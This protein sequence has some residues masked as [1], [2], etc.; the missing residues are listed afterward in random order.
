MSDDD[1]SSLP[2]SV[3]R[4]RWNRPLITPVGGGKPEP[5]TRCTT[6][7]GALEDTY[8]LEKWK[9][10]MTA[11]GLGQRPD[12][13]LAVQACDPARDKEALNGHCDAAVEAAKASAAANMGTAVHK[14]TEA[15]DRGEMKLDDVPAVARPD[16]AAYLDAM[17]LGKL[18]VR[19]IERF[20]VLDSHKI[21][22]TFD[23]DVTIG[24]KGYIAD[25]KTGSLDFG[26]GKIAMQLAVYAHSRA[27]NAETHER[28]D[29]DVDLERAIVIHLPIGT[30]K[31]FLRWV[32]IASGWEAVQLA[33]QVREWR[34]RKDL[35]EVF[36]Y[37]KCER[38]DVD[39]EI[40]TAIALAPDVT[41]LNLVWS[42]NAARWTPAHS[43]AAKTRK[44]QL[45]KEN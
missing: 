15:V 22:G 2:A 38:V 35:S 31:C 44:A 3:K 41:S 25:V 21:G 33:G 1:L 39:D 43:A 4:D 45:T 24:N 26:M 16:V 32:D 30:G 13:L 37:G 9:M 40:M 17:K 10:R 8:N 28:T 14:L 6:Y 19:G 11:V 27:Y 29:L 34:K 12:L 5:Y 36:E 20:V 23:R 7:V 42:N 18:K